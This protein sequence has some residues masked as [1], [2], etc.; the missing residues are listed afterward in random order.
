MRRYEDKTDNMRQTVFILVTLLSAAIP[1]APALAQPA[2]E[3]IR[4]IVREHVEA[5]PT[6]RYKQGREEQ[7]GRQTKTFRIGT[8]GDLSVSNIAGDIVVT[9]VFDGKATAE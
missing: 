3:P 7:T 9:R 1:A 5:A 6:S 8:D 2:P 4:A